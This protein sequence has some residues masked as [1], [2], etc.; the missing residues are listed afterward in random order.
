INRNGVLEVYNLNITKEERD[1][2][3]KSVDILRETL[4]TVL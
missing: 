4:Q 2:L 3:H 1:Q